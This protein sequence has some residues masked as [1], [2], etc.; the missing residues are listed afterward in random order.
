MKPDSRRTRTR[1]DKQNLEG[2]LKARL[3]RFKCFLRGHHCLFGK[4]YKSKDYSFPRVK[5]WE[6]D[7]ST[8]SEPNIMKLVGI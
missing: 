1:L 7:F 4:G 6:C 8:M 3:S 5:Y 2:A